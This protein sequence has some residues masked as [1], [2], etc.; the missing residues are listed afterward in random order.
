MRDVAVI[1]VG[2][3]KWGELWDRSIRDLFA[4]AALNALDDAGVEKI[5]ALFVGCMTG[6]LFTGQEHIGALVAD[7]LGQPA[8]PATRTE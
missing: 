2:L 3:S 1:G 5:E 6:G 4:E 7:Y 8:I